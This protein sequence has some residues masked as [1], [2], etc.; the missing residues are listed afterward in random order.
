M[1]DSNRPTHEDILALVAGLVPDIPR[2][3]EI[4]AEVE[5]GDKTLWLEGWCDGCIAGRG[6]PPKGQGMLKEK[7]HYIREVTPRFLRQRAEER[8]MTVE[9]SGFIPLKDKE[10]LYGVSWAVFIKKPSKGL[11]IIK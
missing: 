10:H 6:F 8:D 2:P 4:I 11:R 9:W 3:S 5:A 1:K 7:L